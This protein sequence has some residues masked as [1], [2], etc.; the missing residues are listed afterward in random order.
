MNIDFESFDITFDGAKPYTAKTANGKT[1]FASEN[2]DGALTVS[3]YTDFSEKPLVLRAKNVRGNTALRVRP[4]RLELWA[5]GV[6]HDEEWQ[7]G[8]LLLLNSEWNTAPEVTEF[9]EDSSPLPTV[10]GTF[11][12]AEGWRPEENVFVGDCM[13]YSDSKRFHVIYLKDRHHHGSKW[14]RG[15][16]QWSH[17]STDDF[18]TWQIHPNVVEIDDPSEGSICTGSHIECD[19]KHYLYYTVRTCDGSPAAI[20]RSISDDGYHYVKD[21]E[22]GF[23]L[24]EKYNSASARDPKV[25]LSDDGLYHMILTSTLISEGKGCLVHLTSPD[26]ENWT[27]TDEPIYVAPDGNEPECPD[28]FEFGGTYYLV[29]SHH[30]KA[31][32]MYSDR[33]FTDWK[34]P[35]KSNIPCESVPKAAIWNGKIVFVGFRCLGGYGGTM[36]FLEVKPEGK[37]LF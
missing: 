10:L 35:E 15:A 14:G 3:V 29:F 8:K 24:S 22:F 2:T 11:K 31:Q 18:V 12:N 28:Y 6:L 19:G 9:F 23:T 34:V 16:H 30:I 37:E 36:T 32:Y 21:R 5:D 7:Y 1:A 27:E 25:V 26:A 20:R 4:Y 17:I 13:P 33:P